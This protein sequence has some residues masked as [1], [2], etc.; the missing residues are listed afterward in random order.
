MSPERSIMQTTAFTED[1][2]GLFTPKLIQQVSLDH[3]IS[4]EEVK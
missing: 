4:K 1:P 3:I 2:Y